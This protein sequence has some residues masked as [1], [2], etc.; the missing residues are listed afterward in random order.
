MPARILWR[1]WMSCSNICGRW[2]WKIPQSLRRR[3]LLL[4]WLFAM[5]SR[6]EIAHLWGLLIWIARVNFRAKISKFPRSQP[7]P[8]VPVAMR[9]LVLPADPNE[10]TADFRAAAFRPDGVPVQPMLSVDEI[11]RLAGEVNLR[12]N[13][14]STRS[15]VAAAPLTVDQLQMQLMQQQQMNWQLMQMQ[16]LQQR[17]PRSGG[18]NVT[19]LP[20][21]EKP[22]ETMLNRALTKSSG[23]PSAS[24]SSR[25]CLED[26]KEES[27]P[28]AA[29]HSSIQASQAVP[30]SDAALEAPEKKVEESQSQKLDD[31]AKP[32]EFGEAFTSPKQKGE[33]SVSLA[34]S[35]ARLQIARVDGA[36]TSP[37]EESAQPAR[38]KKRPA[39][40]AAKVASKKAKPQ[41]SK[42]V[43]AGSGVMKKPAMALKRPAGSKDAERKA[44]LS[45][46][47]AAVRKQ[48]AN[49]CSK[50]RYTTCTPSCWRGRGYFWTWQTH[51]RDC[52]V[53]NRKCSRISWQRV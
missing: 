39:A 45:K 13:N 4:C 25:L 14:T 43:P 46:V 38:A 1:F 27:P 34:A 29:T 6:R 48:F 26:Q 9:P 22:F 20:P 12:S 16:M 8:L 47:P 51:Q 21:K 17:S 5:R 28:V 41:T 11:L 3:F 2:D 30:S 7:D 36:M 31:T 15:V 19:L 50:C 52:A 24:S 44:I 42:D 23:A 53:E 18:A 32:L 10:V 35:M 37:D 40:A 33:P 49:G